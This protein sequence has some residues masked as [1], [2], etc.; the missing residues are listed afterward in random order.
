MKLVADAGGT[1]TDWRLL[2]GDSIQQFSTPGYNPNTHDLGEYLDILIAKFSSLAPE[3]EQLHF[4]GASIYPKNET[5]RTALA[6]LFTQAEI[7]LN[8]DLVGS[9]R[10]LSADEPAFV[11]ILGTG[12]AGCFYDG[13]QVAIHPP[14]LGYTIGD[15]GSGAVLGKTL[16]K[17]GLRKKFEPEFQEKFDHTF[18]VTKEQVYQH[19]YKADHANAY[20]AS[21][22]KFIGENRA[23]PQIHE[24]LISEFRAYYSAF[25]L[26]MPD[27]TRFPFHFTGSVAYFF[28]DYLRKIGTENG[29]TVGRIIQ[30]PIAGLALYHQNHE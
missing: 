13:R 6:T 2:D 25:F 8:N 20:L 3:I 7:Y 21:F 18:Q 19:V 5:F 16:L 15:E 17:L 26:D 12:S 10:A 23:H 29:L 22:T 1:K 9:C 30:S 14:S 28:G 27:I 11:G 24:L 4:Y